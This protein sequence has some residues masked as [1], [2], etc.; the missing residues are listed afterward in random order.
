ME[1]VACVMPEPP[2]KD[3]D[4][5]L[6]AYVDILD[7]PCGK[8]AYQLAK[9]GY[10]LGISSRGSGDLITGP[11][12][13]EEVDP[14]TYSLTAFDLVEIPAVQSA[15][16]SFVESLD[17]K[18]Y[19]KTLRQTLTESLKKAS[20]EDRKLMKES[21]DSLGITLNEELNESAAQELAGY[22]KEWQE[23]NPDVELDL[24]IHEYNG[25]L[26]SIMYNEADYD[27]FVKWAKDEHAITINPISQEDTISSISDDDISIEE[28]EADISLE[29]P[30]EEIS[31]E[32]PEEEQLEGLEGEGTQL[33]DIQSSEGE[34]LV[35]EEREEEV[36]DDNSFYVNETPYGFTEIVYK[37]RVITVDGDQ[38]SVNIDGDE[39]IEDSLDSAVATIEELDAD[40]EY[41]VDPWHD[42]SD[43]KL[44]SLDAVKETL[45]LKESMYVKG[46]KVAESAGR[47]KA[48]EEAEPIDEELIEA[49]SGNPYAEISDVIEN[50]ID[51]LDTDDEIG[52]LLQGII[53]Y[54][55]SIAEDRGLLVEE[56]EDESLSD[57]DVDIVESDEP[58]AELKEAL[59]LK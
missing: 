42:P 20:V 44:A 16:L 55:R 48:I 25:N 27:K 57:T 7:T 8:I 10:K 32:E 29:E 5:Q 40:P 37:G 34:L 1:K 9:Y 46:K 47:E 2:V 12:G 23:A 35:E 13:E 45:G 31:L 3:K 28:P 59:E 54:C 11:D 50:C 6:V 22:F 43:L 21:L 17:T 49:L 15:R 56:C 14:D 30:E 4:G 58:V 51:E 41:H 33:A 53:G 18:R 39:A 36:S 19:G 38:I 52:D 24:L 26:G